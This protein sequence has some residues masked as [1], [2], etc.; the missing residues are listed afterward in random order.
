[1]TLLL[2][3]ATNAF[4]AEA[5]LTVA[6]GAPEAEQKRAL[7]HGQEGAEEEE[8]ATVPVPGTVQGGA[9]GGLRGTFG[10][11][12]TE[13]LNAGWFGRVEIEGFGTSEYRGP[14]PVVE[15]LMGGEFW[16]TD[17][18]S[19]GGM[20]ISFGFGYR[21]PVIFSS[22]GFGANLF[23]V[24]KVHDDGGFGIYAPFG[25]LCLGV[26]I[27]STFRVLAEGRAT[28]RWQWGAP[29]RGQFQA[30]LTFAQMFESP[31]KNPPRKPKPKPRAAVWA[32]PRAAW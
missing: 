12:F 17:E 3:A 14:G 13:G 29:D 31:V 21:T 4:A 23:I 28:Y 9:G 25:S 16:T 32:P 15:A 20:P 11:V 2:F 1:V 22:I 18:G 8:D 5:K 24:D 19:G 27:N 26:E 7:E 6:V 10:R 30:G